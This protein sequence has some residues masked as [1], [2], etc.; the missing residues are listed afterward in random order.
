MVN[1]TVRVAVFVIGGG[2]LLYNLFGRPASNNTRSFEEWEKT[3]ERER[4]EVR[5]RKLENVESDW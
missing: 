3:I 4:E 1:P 2:R 5:R